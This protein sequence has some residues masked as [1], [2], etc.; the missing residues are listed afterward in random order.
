MEDL[1]ELETRAHRACADLRF[2]EGLRRG[3]EEARAEAAVQEAVLLSWMEGARG[4]AAELRELTTA[5]KSS[6]QG[7][8]S[9]AGL[10]T[11]LGIWRA[12]WGVESALSPLNATSKDAVRQVRRPTPIPAML[13]TINK[14][15]CSVLAASGHVKTEQVAIAADPASLQQVL[16][17]AGSSQGS[18]TSRAAEIL[19]LMLTQKTF[20]VGNNPTAFLFVK[21]L[22][23]QQGVEPTGVA[24][25][26][27]LASQKQQ[28]FSALIR[29]DS[30]SPD[31]WH[32]FVLLSLVEG[33]QAGQQI[34]RSVQAGVTLDGSR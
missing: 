23:A 18:A 4:S 14:E 5:G 28:D 6:F 19:R 26:P 2:A 10:A 16:R 24:L 9:D 1:A 17:L 13:G 8:A 32:R 11:M 30:G 27:L 29:V 15:V 31:P 20:E 12:A 25:L 21:W 7:V 22:L 34:A 33:C 3:W